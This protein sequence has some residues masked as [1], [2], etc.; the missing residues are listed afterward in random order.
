MIGI[1]DKRQEFL[2]T[3]ASALGESWKELE[4]QFCES[5]KG[6]GKG[7]KKKKL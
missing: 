4:M 2:R 5:G 6:Q 3:V 1:S 7:E